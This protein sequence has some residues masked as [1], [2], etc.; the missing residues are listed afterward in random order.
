MNIIFF[1]TPEFAVP[2]LEKLLSH[3]QF[4]VLAV[5]T[6]PDKRRGRG[7]Q[8]TPSP[9]KSVALA[10]ALPVLQPAKLKKDRE[11]LDYLQNSQADVFVVAA[12]G[13]IL[14]QEILDMPRWGCINVHGSL[15]PHY[16]GAAPI[17]W[18]LY[19]GEAETG[20]TTMQMDAGM[21]TGAMLLKRSL[22]IGL[23]DNA[24]DLVH[25]LAQIGADLLIETLLKL[26]PGE[27]KPIP[28]DSSQATYAPLIKKPDYAIDWSRSALALHNQI[29]G[30]YPDCTAH[31]RD[32]T[33]KIL[34]TVP[35]P[36]SDGLL[37]PEALRELAQAYSQL[38]ITPAMPPGTVVGFMKGIGVIVQ[39][40]DGTLLLR[41]VQLSGKRPQPGWDF[42]NGTH[43]ELGDQLQNE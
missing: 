21:D 31:F 18:S 25:K 40:G 26:A 43:L 22:A 38:Q 30:F 6:Q 5:V 29:R 2:T 27:L 39:T 13:Q 1:G 42:A 35:F 9:V 11:T 37:L 7:N 10:H 14:S 41:E 15:L 32:Q 33:L 4:Q 24:H 8:L 23:L 20:I 3:P 19:N 12:Y 36:A 16:R 17:Q 28:Q 34:A